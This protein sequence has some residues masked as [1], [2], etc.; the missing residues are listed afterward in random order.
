M[1]RESCLLT[2]KQIWNEHGVIFGF[3]AALVSSSLKEKERNIGG[4]S[5]GKQ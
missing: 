4:K 1:Y 2:L 5:L 3:G